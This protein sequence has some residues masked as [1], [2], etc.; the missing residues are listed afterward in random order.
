MFG[1]VALA[2]CAGLQHGEQGAQSQFDAHPQSL[3]QL[4][5]Q[6]DFC[7]PQIGHF[8]VCGVT[9]A[10]HAEEQFDP[11]IAGTL[12]LHG[13][14]AFA[15]ENEHVAIPTAIAAATVSFLI[16]IFTSLCLLEVNSHY[17]KRTS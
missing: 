3:L 17:I 9:M 8:A 10:G 2:G 1:S 12:V 6:S 11:V 7:S 14:A 4:H 5:L 13:H 16:V 15:L